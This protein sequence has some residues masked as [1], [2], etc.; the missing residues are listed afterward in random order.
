MLR[1][2]L[3]HPLTCIAIGG[4]L[5]YMFASKIAMVPVVNKLPQF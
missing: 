1:H 4:L 3:S 5:G 2:P